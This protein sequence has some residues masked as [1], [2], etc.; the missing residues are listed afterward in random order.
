M[1]DTRPAARLSNP[2]GS[3]SEAPACLLVS[4]PALDESA[5]IAEVIA[6][7]PR[8]IE[9]VGEVVV[10]V[11]DDGSTD[12]TA[13]L[14]EKAGAHV[15]RHDVTLG[16]G[17][18]FQTALAYARDIGVDLLVTIDADGQFDPAD[19]P[20]V[21][22]PVI[23]GEAD[24]VTG[25][26]FID[27]SLEPEMPRM[28]R[29]GNRQVARIVSGL[30]RRH[31]ED[32]SCGMRCYNREAILHLNLL[33]KFTY[34]HEV[35]LDL[36]FKGLRIV[37]VPIRVRGERAYGTSRVAGSLLR[38]AIHT[39]RILVGA[40]RDYN[41]LR[42]FGSLAAVLAGPAVLLEIFF[43]AHYLA[44]GSFSPHL[45]AGFTGAGLGSLAILMLFM[46][47]IGDMLNRHRV[48][49]EEILYE[50]RRRRSRQQPPVDHS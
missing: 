31:F 14:A 49:L 39:L 12:A 45:W 34:T 13:Q 25:S 3:G 8:Q 33:G 36:C 44:T 24:F 22:A 41:P 42:F 38:Y 48:Y 11:V 10:L 30:T 29:W 47:M 37:E 32:V 7:I 15:I 40:Y 27:P 9:S 26:R 2:I 43:L 50:Q 5:T 18:A 46:G 1:S 28:K 19:I 17:A 20:V 16:V 21:M 23:A 6:G 35:L 4:L